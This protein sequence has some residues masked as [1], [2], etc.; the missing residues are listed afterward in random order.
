MNLCCIMH[1]LLFYT[2]TV[3][4]LSYRLALPHNIKFSSIYTVSIMAGIYAMRSLPLFLLPQPH[5]CCPSLCHAGINDHDR[6]LMS[7]GEK[8]SPIM[9]AFSALQLHHHLIVGAVICSAT[10]C[11]LLQRVMIRAQMTLEVNVDLMWTWCRLASA[12]LRGD[13]NVSVPIRSGRESW[14]RG[15]HWT[16]S[17]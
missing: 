8:P 10:H 5:S 1:K 14:P 11:F 9:S 7:S 4:F 15:C 3:Y 6:R 16:W 13:W 2:V 12:E 17:N